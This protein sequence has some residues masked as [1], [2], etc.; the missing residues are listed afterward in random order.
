MG[1]G[2][3]MTGFYGSKCTR[4]IIGGVGLKNVILDSVTHDGRHTLLQS[5]GG[6]MLA[7]SINGFDW[8]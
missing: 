3:V 7:I 1:Q 5:L 2:G 6:V 8:G 4:H